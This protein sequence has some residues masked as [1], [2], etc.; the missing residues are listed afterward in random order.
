MTPEQIAAFRAQII[1]GCAK[2]IEDYKAERDNLRA[3]LDAL[4]PRV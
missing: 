1:E 2:A 3:E 4:R